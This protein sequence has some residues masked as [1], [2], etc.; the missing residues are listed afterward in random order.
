MVRLA[1]HIDKTPVSNVD[2]G[3]KCPVQAPAAGRSGGT[4]PRQQSESND[5]VCADSGNVRKRAVVESVRIMGV[6]R[7]RT[8]DGVWRWQTGG[9]TSADDSYSGDSRP[10]LPLASP[11][12][13]RYIERM[14]LLRR[15]I[16]QPIHYLHLCRSLYSNRL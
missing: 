4:V 1:P 8:G 3:K 12:C 16:N 6:R 14:F 11:S 7:I 13:P 5:S 2:E 9:N 10:S 15:C